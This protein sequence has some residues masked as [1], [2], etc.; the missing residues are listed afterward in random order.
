ML[1]NSKR[2]IKCRKRKLDWLGTLESEELCCDTWSLFL[3][4]I[5]TVLRRALQP[6]TNRHRQKKEREN[7]RMALSF[8]PSDQESGSPVETWWGDSY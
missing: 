8:W 2:S 4:P 6:V 3:S 1:Y 5:Y 7:A